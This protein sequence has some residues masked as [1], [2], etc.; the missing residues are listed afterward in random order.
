M[1]RILMPLVAVA[2]FVADFITKYWAIQTLR[3][4]PWN[5]Q[6]VIPGILD[7][8]WAENQGG[9]FS[10]LHG[11]VWIITA[12]SIVAM[13]GVIW[14]SRTL[15]K[16]L[17]SAH[18]ALGAIIGG[19]I[20]NLVDRIRFQYVVDFIHFY[21]IRNGKEYYW[22]TFNVADM[23][24]VCGILWFLYLSFFTKELDPA[25]KTDEAETAST[26][27]PPVVQPTSSS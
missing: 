24:I 11:R 7:F 23:G 21:F 13:V 2:V 9:A 12:F 4:N 8:L 5:R 26:T 19:A 25:L 10:I 14:W 16:H 15:P 20:G 3:P 17:I 1:T 27:E 6:Q 22:P 18:I